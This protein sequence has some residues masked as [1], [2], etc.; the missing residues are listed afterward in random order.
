MTEHELK[1][2]PEPFAAVLDGSKSHEVRKFDRDYKVGDVLVLR[3]WR[4]D[5]PGP[6]GAAGNF[7]GRAIRVGITHVTPPGQFHLPPDVG[8]LSI[9]PLDGKGTTQLIVHLR[10]ALLAGK[11][12]SVGIR[13][14][15]MKK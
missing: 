7:T 2:W 10:R 6:G 15:R 11:S 9:T 14:P 1:C 8:V 4:R 12:V 5:L 13:N 3:E